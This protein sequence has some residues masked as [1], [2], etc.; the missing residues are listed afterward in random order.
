M[1]VLPPRVVG[2][3]PRGSYATS[4]GGSAIND[5]QLS[6]RGVRPGVA[7]AA[8]LGNMRSGTDRAAAVETFGFDSPSPSQRRTIS[9]VTGDL[10][11]L[12]AQLP[13]ALASTST[14][15]LTHK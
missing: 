14:E 13:P 3:S 8:S 6:A 12:V 4:V 10:A 1:R 9:E 7:C 2:A 5:E 11:G 15:H